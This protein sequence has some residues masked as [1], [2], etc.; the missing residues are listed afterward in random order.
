MVPGTRLLIEHS[1]SEDADLAVMQIDPFPEELPPLELAAFSPG[2]DTPVW[3]IGQGRDRGTQIP[4][5]GWVWATTSS[6]RWGTNQIGGFVTGIG[7]VAEVLVPGV[8]NRLT[9][10]LVTQFDEFP[11]TL[12]SPHECIATVGDS[13]GGLFVETSPGQFALAGI[14]IAI[15]QDDGQDPETSLYGNDTFSADL[16]DDLVPDVEDNCL[17][18]PNPDQRDSNADGYGNLC[19]FDYNDDEQTAGPD[20]IILSSGFG[21]RAGEPGFDED[22]DATGDGLIGSDEFVL[23]SGAYEQPPGPSGLACAGS[24]PCP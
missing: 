19:D 5:Q 18:V 9:R 4:G 21:I 12:V 17:D 7:T 3:M 8:S 11:N 13:G 14:Q 24:T 20:Y 15:A 6:K 23:F 1:S 16:D 22:L 2:F 10:A